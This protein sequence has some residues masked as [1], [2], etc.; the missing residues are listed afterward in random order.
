MRR[1]PL[2]N[3]ILRSTGLLA[4]AVGVFLL[5][6]GCIAPRESVRPPE[7]P[8]PQGTLPQE[9]PE[10]DPARLYAK[11]KRASVEIIVD[12]HLAGSGWFADS[13]GLIVTAAHMMNGWGA[14][15][16]V[17]RQSSDPLPARVL[18]VDQGHDLAL[19]RLK[20]SGTELAF[21]ALEVAESMPGPGQ[22]VYLFGSALYRHRI[23][24][25][26]SVARDDLTYEFLGDRGHFVRV[27]HVA[28][29]SPPG[30][31]GGCWTDARGRVVGVQ[32]AFITNNGKSTGIADVAP[33]DAIHSLLRTRESARTPTLGCGLEE[34]PT[35][36]PGFIRRLPEGTGG[37]V[38][39]P[40][41]AGGPADK[42]GL[43]KES[44]IVALD[45]QP[46]RYRDEFLD[47]IRRKDPGEEV[48]LKIIQPDEKKHRVVK[49]K[50]ENLESP[51][52]H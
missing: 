41:Q 20:Q 38:T 34:L 37:L 47:R 52:S 1:S 8:T 48:T 50:L 31:S 51:W 6:C 2:M 42:A 9:T 23:M 18:A 35:Q 16:E 10:L 12:G 49:I 29:P 24:L 3:H 15:I 14:K 19:L 39:I 17:V 43:N 22:D 26:G 27:Y 11:L 21:E 7:P 25:R 46:V 32:S 40:I 44:V 28:S 45:G 30:T 13:S 5:A 36:Q 4:G 33:P